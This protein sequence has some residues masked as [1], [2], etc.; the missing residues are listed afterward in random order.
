MATGPELAERLLHLRQH[1]EEGRR[2]PHKPLLVLMALGKLAESG[3]SRMDW[4]EV[5]ERLAGLLEEFGPPRRGGPKPEYPFTRLRSDMVWELSRD[6]PMD[7]ISPLRSADISGQF[8]KEL[9]EYFHQNTGEI[10]LKARVLIE[11]QYPTSVATEVLSAVG[12]DPDL[13]FAYGATPA[14]VVE[15]RR[16]S[17]VWRNEVLQA[18]DRCCAFCGFDGQVGGG[19]VGLEAAHIRWFNFG[20]PDDLENGLALCSLHHKLLDR[21]VLGFD[22]P[23]T[24]VVSKAYSARSE[25][26]KRVYDL[27][28]KR[29]RPRPGTALPA[30]E[31]VLWHS[32]EVFKGIALD[33]DRFALT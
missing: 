3:S 21:G 14:P 5:E 11:Q 23:E 17:A 10:F 13:V 7:Q 25:A 22:D 6:V 28:S 26:G 2:S 20:G 18:W 33:T 4:S 27:H 19:P 12:L 29:I 24:V 8:V 32:R 30:E 9:E 31:H 1:Q 16:R 15:E